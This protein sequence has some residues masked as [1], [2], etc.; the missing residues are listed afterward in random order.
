MKAKLLKNKGTVRQV[1]GGVI[2]E[3]TSF[4]YG[5]GLYW[6]RCVNGEKTIW[7]MQARSNP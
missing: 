7:Q 4:L 6:M 5:M 3:E 1:K 2:F